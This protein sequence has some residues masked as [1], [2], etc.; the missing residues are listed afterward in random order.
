MNNK[1]R[2]AFEKLA[3]K[4]DDREET[5]NLAL[6]LKNKHGYLPDQYK[7]LE[8]FFNETPWRKDKTIV[9]KIKKAAR[10]MAKNA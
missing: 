2:E 4:M 1:Y 9:R 10:Q 8:R 6:K 3:A 7:H 5:I